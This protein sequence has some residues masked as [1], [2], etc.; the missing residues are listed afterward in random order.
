MQEEPGCCGKTRWMQEGC[1]FL[2]CCGL[3][4]S[5]NAAGGTSCM[6]ERYWFCFAAGWTS[7]DA[8]AVLQRDMFWCGSGGDVLLWEH[9]RC[10][11]AGVQ[12]IFVAGVREMF[13]Y[14]AWFFA[15]TTPRSTK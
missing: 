6:Q 8:G 15:S 10:F 2:F 12:E 5:C 11:N 7:G 14:D 13:C 3:D 4:D 9:R 1:C